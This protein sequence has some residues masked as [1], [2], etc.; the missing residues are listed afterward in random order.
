MKRFL[1]FGILAC[2]V[3]GIAP[4]PT[5]ACAADGKNGPRASGVVA[6]LR[7]AI[8]TVQQ[9]GTDHM[10]TDPI[11]SAERVLARLS[12][13][14]RGWKGWGGL[15]F[16]DYED[17]VKAQ[18]AVFG[19]SVAESDILKLKQLQKIAETLSARYIVSF[20]VN[21]L[22]AYHSGDM[23][24]TRQGG[25]ATITVTVFDN[26]VHRFVW[27]DTKTETS[28][29]SGLIGGGSAHYLDQALLNC[30][31]TSLTPFARGE[32]KAVQ[33]KSTKVV[34]KITSLIKR[35]NTVL[36]DLGE[37]SGI[38]VGETL[39]SFDGQVTVKIVEVFVNGSCA[40]IVK[41]VPEKEMPLKSDGT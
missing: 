12:R 19:P 31:R 40:E 23:L 33:T 37:S 1:A 32:T 11:E 6:I 17:T 24:L 14:A 38:T 2:I 15:A 26:S 7:P 21:D 22:S 8:E 30:L 35:G 41:G 13:E 3:A 4:H 9:A 29:H 39:T 28:I 27:Q 5:H 25:R 36:L 34:A 10:S 18:D 16:I 20:K